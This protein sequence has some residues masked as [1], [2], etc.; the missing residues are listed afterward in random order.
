MDVYFIILFSFFSHI[1]N[2]PSPIKINFFTPFYIKSNDILFEFEYKSESKTEL[3]CIFKPYLNEVIFGQILL[4]TNLT[5]FQNN[6]ANN[7]TDAVYMKKFI[8]NKQN[9]LIINSPNIFKKGKE[10]FYIYLIG[11]LACT[12]ELFSLKEIKNLEINNSYFF[13]N[14]NGVSQ[15]FLSLKIENLTENIY[16]NI[17]LFN[18]TCSSLEIIKNKKKISCHSKIK[19][20]LLLEKKNEYLIKYNLD[21]LNY[22]GINFHSEIIQSLD[23]KSKSF[24]FL[25]NSIFNYSIKI[26]DYQIDDYF[27][28][29]FDY[30]IKFSLEGDYFEKKENIEEF[31]NSIKATRYQYFITKKNDN[32]SNYFI[33]KIKFLQNFFNKIKI[34]KIDE[35][36]FIKNF[37]FKYTI[38]KEKIYL[39]LLYKDLIDYFQN[40]QS[41]I[42]LSFD[43]ENGMNIILNNHRGLFKEKI[44]VSK[45]DEINAISFFNLDKEGLFEITMLSENYN[46]LVNSNHLISESQKTNL[47]KSNIGEKIEIISYGNRKIL[48]INLIMGNIDIYEVSDLNEDINN[49][50]NYKQG[51]K[52]IKNQTLILKFKINSYSLYEIFYQNYEKDI[53]FI[54]QDSKI[55]YFSKYI[56]YKLFTV[57]EN[58]KICIKLLNSNNSELSLFYN[59]EKNILN[60]NNSYIIIEN[61]DKIEIEGNNSLVYFLLPL[62]D[63][64]NYT[65]SNSQSGNFD[66]IKEIF[67][68]PEKTEHDI[69]D[70]FITVNCQNCDNKDIPLFF[71]VDYNI[72]PFSRNKYDLI[73]KISLIGYKK[74]CIS[75]YNFIKNDNATHLQNERFFIFLSFNTNVN[76][77]YEINYFDY[78]I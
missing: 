10:K 39:F 63:N 35:I 31:K 1:L 2:I 42:K 29:I 65:I 8:Y 71:Y 53:H 36:Y 22:F 50:S 78:K 66:N 57:Y 3:V 5:N 23:E 17:L 26:K 72:I 54:S 47:Y 15:N 46:Q 41:Y 67:I 68:L 40:Y 9:S 20:L 45:I 12:F 33:F 61:I 38:K 58:N 30:S 76:M 56:K 16:M 4:F 32:Q 21:N 51:L 28:F 48:Y 70:I 77:K 25:S 37:P 14:F 75:I 60:S 34:R 13:T 6:D 24:Y 62:T 64:S 27:G 59:E 7:I 52:E 44:F 19:D 55:L 49:M 11:N 18:R 69:I 73:N 74:K 43:Y